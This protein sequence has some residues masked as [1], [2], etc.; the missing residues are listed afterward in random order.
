MSG[1]ACEQLTFSLEDFH[2]SHFPWLESKKEKGTIVT[3]G[4]RCYELSESCARVALS[5]K[6]CLESSSLPPG[7]WQRIWSVQAITS[8]CLI[9][10][11][12]L[13]ERGTDDQ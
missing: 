11:L 6:T 8:S 12:R 1:Q 9:L 10:R 5:V 2:A 13:S 7:R 4:R 3:S